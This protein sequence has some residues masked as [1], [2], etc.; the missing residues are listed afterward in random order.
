M[1]KLTPEAR[2]L[3]KVRRAETGRLWRAANA[4]KRRANGAAYYRAN[5]GRQKAHAA[6][7]YAAN[8][9]RVRAQA[10]VW[11]AAHPDTVLAVRHRAQRKRRVM[12]KEAILAAYGRVCAHCG[13]ADSRALCI[14]HVA[15]D[16][17]LHRRTVSPGS[18]YQWLVNHGYP[19]GFQ[20][21]CANCNLIKAIE[22]GE[23]GPRANAS[24]GPELVSQSDL[25]KEI[26]S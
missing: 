6:R 19:L 16:G 8:K 15:G 3:A 21:L 23:F 4:E 25:V 24:R 14:D 26:V 2:E 11:A 22:E 10:L 18:M 12:L 9:A 1:R 17:Y 7:W 13:Y 20:V 5:K